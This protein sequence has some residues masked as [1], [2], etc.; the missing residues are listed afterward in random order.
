MPLMREGVEQRGSTL[1]LV[2]VL[3]LVRS[4]RAAAE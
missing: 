1:V 4:E 2:L 3:V